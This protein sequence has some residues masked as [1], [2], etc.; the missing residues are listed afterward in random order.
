M[1]MADRHSEGL[2][3]AAIARDPEV[4]APN[5]KRRLSGVTSTIVQLVPEQARSLRI[6]TLGPGLPDGL[7]RMGLGGLLSLWRRPEGRN[8]RIWHARRNVEM[9]AGIVLRDVLRAPLRLV[10]TS[11][12]Q[13]RHKPFTRWLIARMDAVIATSARSGSFLDVPYTVVRHGIDLDRFA[14]PAEPG[15][16]F[17]ATGLPG[18]HA[19]GC[20]GRVRHQ[21]GTD[22]F[23]DAMIALLPHHPDWTAV[24]T[25]RVTPDNAAFAAEL[26]RRVAAAGLSDRIRF[27]GEVPD[28]KAWY[29]RLALY[30]AP[31]RNE[32]FGLT[33]LEAMAGGVACVASDAGAY[34]E[35]IEEGV[36]GAVVRAGDGEALRAAIEPYLADPQRALDH[37]R[38]AL[39]HVRS[40]FPLSG[41]A[42]GICA[43]YE[44][45]WRGERAQQFLVVARDNSYGLTRDAMLLRQALGVERTGFATSRGRGL[46]SRLARRRHACTIIHLERVHTAWLSAGARNLLV[47]NQERF[48]QRQFGRLRHIVGVLAKSRHAEAIFAERGVPTTYIGFSSQDRLDGSVAKD[49]SRF[50]HLAGGSTLKGTEDVL[51]LWRAHPE[52]PELVLVQKAANA[53]A[54]VPANVTLLSG[55]ISD[56]ALK[57]LQN[58]C[59][60]HLCPS[61]SE[62]WGHH[63]VEGLST[64]AVVLTTDAPPMNELVSGGCGIL[65]PAAR[66]EPR[67][68]GTNFFVDTAALE[69]A[70]AG[71]I[72][73]PDAAKTALGT[74]A[75]LRYEAIA[76]GFAKAVAR[77][78]PETTPG[79]TL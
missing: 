13:R 15:G 26:E 47:P 4:L 11:A 32:G 66:S 75:R 28:I 73:M 44:R 72:A 55:Y 6:A 35:M 41:E 29:R 67:H 71:L 52:W 65:V 23:V 39:A 2:S 61:R 14:P 51:A 78:A 30:V 43:V 7:P 57:R 63:I 12:A 77:L 31:S 69:T 60:I 37:G 5:L 53:P 25:G 45:V 68:L 62:G 21:K 9:V 64:G 48:P 42:A 56:A 76:A 24:I 79:A 59:G 54:A 46:L 27:L 33:P 8:V 22:L 34:A 58:E 36:T 49:W 16:D 40:V 20:F 3:G 74:A 1:T 38:A 10:F 18:R 50:F 70:I 19:I 17:A